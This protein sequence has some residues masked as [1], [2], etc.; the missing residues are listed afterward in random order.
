MNIS[1]HLLGML[2]GCYMQILMLNFS[3]G[4]CQILITVYFNFCLL[5]VIIMVDHYI[6][7][8]STQYFTAFP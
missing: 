2:S 6:L 1:C 7:A 4:L 8:A 5:N 3:I